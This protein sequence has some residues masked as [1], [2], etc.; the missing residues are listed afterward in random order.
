MNNMDRMNW[1]EYRNNAREIQLAKSCDSYALT[2]VL[3]VL[4]AVAT[5][6]I[7][8]FLNDARLIL[9]LSIIPVVSFCTTLI[10]FSLVKTE[11]KYFRRAA[12][13]GIVLTVFFILEFVMERLNEYLSDN[14]FW[15]STDAYFSRASLMTVVKLVI[16]A[17]LGLSLVF[18]VI[19][20]NLGLLNGIREKDSVVANKYFGFLMVEYALLSTLVLLAG[21]GIY[22]QA[23][24]G[25]SR[26]SMIIVA[27]NT[28]VV[29]I[30]LFAFK[31]YYLKKIKTLFR[32]DR[33][34]YTLNLVVS[35][36]LFFVVTGTYFGLNYVNLN[37]AFEKA[38]MMWNTIYLEEDIPSTMNKSD[39]SNIT[40]GISDLDKL[41]FKTVSDYRDVEKI[42]ELGLY[43]DNTTANNIRI[44]AQKKN[45]QLVG[46]ESSY[47]YA[48]SRSPFVSDAQNDIGKYMN[49]GFDDRVIWN[50][51]YNVTLDDGK[52][53]VVVAPIKLVDK[54]LEA[55]GEYAVLPV[56]QVI[57]R[58]Q[59]S[60]YCFAYGF[61]SERYADCDFV[62]DCIRPMSGWSYIMG[63][64][65]LENYALFKVIIFVCLGII[66]IGFPLLWGLREKEYYLF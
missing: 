21:F 57:S 24:E 7:K 28:I 55:E 14:W 53:L 11:K 62:I 8:L 39:L 47:I 46:V 16:V 56:G 33:G 26:V 22:F 40:Q 45:V 50:G 48:A 35:L 31:Y 61:E 49:K 44:R 65:C 17:V 15:V 4:S 59:I 64:Y 25:I 29:E 52:K 23:K 13:F 9:L 51:T 36:L 20:V 37:Y 41:S 58:K 12:R 10:M 5:T 3:Y 6:I 1:D 30:C 18:S 19:N 60:H 63:T 32:K 42:N 38:E 27:V 43:G 34:Q 2:L 66:S 54:A